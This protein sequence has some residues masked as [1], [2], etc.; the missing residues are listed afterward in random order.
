MPADMKALLRKILA[1]A[2]EEDARDELATL[3]EKVDAGGTV[4]LAQIREAI[5]A[6]PPEERAEL[7]K[8]LAEEAEQPAPAS[9]P[10][11]APLPT[12]PPTDPVDEVEPVD[13]KV[14]KRRGRKRG[15]VYEDD[16]EQNPANKEQ[17]RHVRLP[18]ARIYEGEDEPDVVEYQEW[19]D[20][21]PEET[22]EKAS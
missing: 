16:F 22:E 6:A 9:E 18:L 10:A 20:E 21:E 1:E 17:Y 4:T 5:S 13:A 12:P 3:K 11:P 7:R 8:L 14:R 19:T 15:L 2:E